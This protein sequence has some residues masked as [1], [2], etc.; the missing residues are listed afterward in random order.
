VRP[1]T[2]K[3][4]IE[5]VLVYRCLFVKLSIKNVVKCFA[6]KSPERISLKFGLNY[7]QVRVILP[8]ILVLVCCLV[9][10]KK[11]KKIEKKNYKIEIKM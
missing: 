7:F 9:S 2:A 5:G 11:I 10:E 4:P 1:P 8:P 6:S 3:S